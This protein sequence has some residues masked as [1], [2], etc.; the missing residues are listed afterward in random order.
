[1]LSA[2]Q[3]LFPIV[4]AHTSSQEG[5]RLRA[6]DYVTGSVE[7]RQLRSVFKLSFLDITLVN[8]LKPADNETVTE[9]E[10]DTEETCDGSSISSSQK[11]DARNKTAMRLHV[12]LTKKKA[13]IRMADLEETG[14]LLLLD[15]GEEGCICLGKTFGDF[16]QVCLVAV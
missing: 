16:D 9:V 10:L 1:M 12:Y 2:F 14:F 8:R 13:K 15:V 7:V 11:R 4:D 5:D 3:Y 6:T